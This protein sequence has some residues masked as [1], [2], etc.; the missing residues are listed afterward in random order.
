MGGGGWGGGGGLRIIARFYGKWR[1]IQSRII[2]EHQLV[3]LYSLCTLSLYILRVD[4]RNMS[5]VN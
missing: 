2:L 1:E 5:D 3:T 4:P